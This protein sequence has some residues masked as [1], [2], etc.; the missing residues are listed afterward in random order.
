LILGLTLFTCFRNSECEEMMLNATSHAKLGLAIELKADKNEYGLR[1]AVVLHITLTNSSASPIYVYKSLHQ[2]DLAGLSVWAKDVVTG[3]DVPRRFISDALPPPPKSKEAFVEI[4]PHASYT[5][6][7]PYTVQELNIAA[8]GTYELFA[9]YQ[10]PIPR[11]MNFGL[12]IWSREKG[13][14]RSNSVKITISR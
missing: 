4:A 12:P 13:A 7:L 10:S 11:T 5:V 9:E 1:D 8:N 14:A 6:D 3:K 2:G